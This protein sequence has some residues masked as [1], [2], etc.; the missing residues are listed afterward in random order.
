LSM[1]TGSTPLRPASLEGSDTRHIPV[2]LEEVIEVLDISDDEQV[3]DGTF[4]A[5]GYSRA[6]LERNASCQVLAID[7]DPDAV[8]GSRDLVHAYNGRLRVVQGRFGEL[9]GLARESGLETVDAVVLDIG[10]SSMQIDDPSRG[11][12]FRA[13]GPL[14]MRMAQSGE[15]AADLVN[16]M[17]ENDLADL[18]YRYGEERRS[19]AVARAI[20]NA[21]RAA[22]IAT[23][24][25]LADLVASVVHLP[26]DA[27]H[28]ATRTFQALRIAVNDELGELERGLAAAEAI[29]APGGRLAVVTF[30]S[31]EDRIV[32]HFI[33]ERSGE[34]PSPS[35]HMPSADAPPATFKNLA[36]KAI[37]A[38]LEETRANPRARSAKLRIAE[39]TMAT[40]SKHSH[41]RRA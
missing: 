18:I 22:P 31:L 2:L 6:I 36:R 30:H 20:V 27:I 32:K 39:R 34:M 9:D 14:D 24:K 23:T 13:D 10:V 37:V 25:Q 28:P 16:T 41:K 35:R 21:R 4:G 38:G 15:T 40:V 33:A 26:P 5:G 3:I 1:M 8:L 7:R 19:R 11:F 29:L 17:E 12:S